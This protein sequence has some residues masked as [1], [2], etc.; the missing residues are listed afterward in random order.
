MTVFLGGFNTSKQIAVFDWT[1][2]KYK[3]LNSQLR[4][5]R[6]LSSCSLLINE[7]GSLLVA[8]FGGFYSSGL[9][10]WNPEDGTVTTL[11]QIPSVIKTRISSQL[12]SINNNKELLLFGGYSKSSTIYHDDVWKYSVTSNSWTNMKNMSG[13]KSSFTILPIQNCNLFT[14]V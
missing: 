4:G 2:L 10:T 11:A 12:I 1:T 13:P 9:E 6:W 14:E 8:V 7:S 5:N 3:R